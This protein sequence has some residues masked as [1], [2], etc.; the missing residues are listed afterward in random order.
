MLQKILR[1]LKL[2]TLRFGELTPTS[3]FFRM[4]SI[5]WFYRCKNYTFSILPSCKNL[6][7][8][9]DGYNNPNPTGRR[10]FQFSGTSWGWYPCELYVIQICWNN[11]R[12]KVATHM[13]I[14]LWHFNSKIIKKEILAICAW[15][16]TFKLRLKQW[17]HVLELE[18]YISSYGSLG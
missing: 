11:W 13:L 14:E 7:G 15:D 18:I 4:L 1:N 9:N 12:L 10:I 17:Q 8:A 2:Q 6:F 3:A 5:T 16:K